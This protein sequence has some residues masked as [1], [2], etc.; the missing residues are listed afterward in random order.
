[1]IA[2]VSLYSVLRIDNTQRKCR[3]E[4]ELQRTRKVSV[5]TKVSVSTRWCTEYG[6]VGS[7]STHA[8]RKVNSIELQR[9]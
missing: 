6:T 2:K 3:R 7:Y 1:L 5:N 4:E 9:S 8:N